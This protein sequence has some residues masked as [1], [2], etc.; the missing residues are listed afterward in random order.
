MKFDES[1]WD[2]IDAQELEEYRDTHF[3]KYKG[4]LVYVTRKTRSRFGSKIEPAQKGEFGIVIG[5]YMSNMG[6]HKLIF[7]DSE[8]RERGTTMKMVRIWGH[9]DQEQG[10][11][12]AQIYESW[13]DATYVPV[14]VTRKKKEF[15]RRHVRE[16][17]SEEW[18]ISRD[19]Q[20][21]LVALLSDTSKIT[22][23]KRDFIHPSD[24][25]SLFQ[26]SLKCCSVRVPLW[27]ATKMG[28][29]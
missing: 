23:L 27:L 29:Y 12:W 22:W 1:I 25:E 3:G 24:H 26:S 16:G 5:E 4:M 18:V 20:S 10:K 8:L 17:S 11:I 19:R 9:K 2:K 28:A 6:T 15:K 7:V 21:V 13:M 14:I